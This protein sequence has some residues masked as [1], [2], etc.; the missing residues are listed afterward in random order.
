[1]PGFPT[2]VRVCRYGG[3]DQ[4]RHGAPQGTLTGSVQS[5]R[6]A[7]LAIALNEGQLHTTPYDGLCPLEIGRPHYVL[8]FAYPDGYPLR[9]DVALESCGITT[10]GVG[11]EFIPRPA[12][13]LLT[14]LIGS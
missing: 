12:E 14:S 13:K 5:S 10:D 1:M 2:A 11:W 4:A 3:V 8:D 7:Q 9:V 6:A